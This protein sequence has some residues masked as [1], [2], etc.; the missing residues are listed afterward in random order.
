[1]TPKFSYQLE[2]SATSWLAKILKTS[3]IR[4]QFHQE[5]KSHPE[6]PNIAQVKEVSQADLKGER[7][8]C[9]TGIAISDKFMIPCVQMPWI[10]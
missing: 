6:H 5:S 3:Q 7:S 10:K 1:M 8:S 9:T 2:M 4:Q